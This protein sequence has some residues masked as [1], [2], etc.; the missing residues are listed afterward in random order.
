VVLLP[1][2]K[3]ALLHQHKVA[4]LLQLKAA[5]LPLH[6]AVPQLQLR[7]VLRLLHRVVKPPVFFQGVFFQ[8]EAL[9]VSQEA[10]LLLGV[11]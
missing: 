11:S 8:E 7:A 4:L 9:G 3:V 1:L 5:L 10:C 2:L 6:K